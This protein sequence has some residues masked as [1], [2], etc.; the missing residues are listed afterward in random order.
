MEKISEIQFSNFSISIKKNK[1]SSFFRNASF[2]F[3]LD[4]IGILLVA[5]KKWK[6]ENGNRKKKQ[7]SQK[8][9]K[10]EDETKK[11]NV[12]AV[13]IFRVDDRPHEKLLNKY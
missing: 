1:S 4:P 7:S 2:L 9:R 6:K 5:T 3:L 8:A 11:E 12:L 10:I 13:R